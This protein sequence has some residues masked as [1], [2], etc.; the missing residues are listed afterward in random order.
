MY[1]TKL[2]ET[3]KEYGIEIYPLMVAYHSSYTKEHTDI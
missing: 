1:Y 2:L 3:V